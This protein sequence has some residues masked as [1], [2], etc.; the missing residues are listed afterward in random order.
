[1]VLDRPKVVSR[2]PHHSRNFCCRVSD[3]ANNRHLLVV[4]GKVPLGS[5]AQPGAHRLVDV[6]DVRYLVPAAQEESHELRSSRSMT[7]GLHRLLGRGNV[8]CTCRRQQALREFASMKRL[9]VAPVRI[10][11]YL[12]T[13]IQSKRPVLEPNAVHA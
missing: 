3:A 1:M 9:N 2:R 10:H 12:M 11:G 13:I 8:K 4:V 7:P 5:E 6:H